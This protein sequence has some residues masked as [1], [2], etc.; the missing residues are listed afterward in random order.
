MGMRSSTGFVPATSPAAAL[1]RSCSF[2]LA[3]LSKLQVEDWN[4][5]SSVYTPPFALIIISRVSLGVAVLASLWLTSDIFYRRGWRSM[6]AVMIPV[7]IVN[8]LYLW[9][10]TVWTYIKYG[11]PELQSKKVENGA[12]EDEE[13]PLLHSGHRI[14]QNEDNINGERRSACSETAPNPLAGHRGHSTGHDVEANQ[15]AHGTSA[16]RPIFATVT[17]ATC[18]CG[19]GCVLGEIVGEWLVYWSDASINESMLYAAF[20]VD[21]V[22]ALAFGIVFQYFSIAPMVGD[23]GWKTVV[24]SAKADFL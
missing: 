13:D 15:N 20:I 18:H 1:L 5:A 23:Y 19:A 6:M 17:V 8:A 10:I 22:F 14:D 24:R 4:M 7:Y 12:D 3:N 16:D 2:C 21:F 9:P 11:R